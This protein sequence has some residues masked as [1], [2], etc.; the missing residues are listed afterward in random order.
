MTDIRVPPHDLD[1]EEAI[2]SGILQ[3]PSII[4]HTR[5]KIS[6]SDFYRESHQ[7]IYQSII[8]LNVSDVVAIKNNLESK[9]KLEH[10]GGIQYLFNLAEAYSTSAGYEHYCTVVKEMAD[11]RKMISLCQTISGLCFDNTVPIDDALLM[12]R[13]GFADIQIRDTLH[14]KSTVD[15]SNIYTSDKMVDAY[16]EYIKSLKSNKFITGIDEIDKRIRGVSGGEVMFIIA[17]AGCFKTAILQNLLQNYTQNSA[18][19]AAF[20]S[21]EMPVAS[22]T[23]RYHEMISGL[24]GREIEDIFV[25]SIEGYPEKTEGLNRD[26][27]ER[28]KGIYII[29]TV[30][31]VKDII[32]YIKLIEKEYEQ[33]VGI[34]GIDYIGLLDGP[35]KGEYEIVSTLS[36]QLKSMAK[37]LN[38]PVIAI[39]QTSRKAGSGDTEISLDMGRGSGAIEETADFLLGLFKSDDA[40]I[41]KILKNRKGTTG[42]S[43][44]LE[45]NKETLRLGHGA[46]YWESDETTKNEQW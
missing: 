45:L 33:K 29:P 20:F 15:T 6:S 16:L 32:Q 5:M 26:F 8:E 40:V 27:K 39:S 28:M 3:N 10:A 36:R 37:L 31:S 11:R 14:L 44:V 42:T 17:R 19:G 9:G 30:V 7:L 12:S 24:T 23:E 21:I 2:L 34:I 1:A 35:G 25:K 4:K 38:I 43:W 41:C 18:W 22:I 46:F 13:N